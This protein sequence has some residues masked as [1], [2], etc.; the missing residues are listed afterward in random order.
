MYHGMIDFKEPA[1]LTK[2]IRIDHRSHF[3]LD[4]IDPAGGHDLDKQ[5]ANAMLTDDIERLAKLQNAS[6]PTINGRCSW[7]C[8]AWTPPARTAS[9][10]T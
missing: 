8:R 10:S 2:Q 9:S 6:T 3:A 1:R 5:T 7:C 4:S